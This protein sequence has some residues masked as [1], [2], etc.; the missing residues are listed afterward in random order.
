MA[1][2]NILKKYPKIGYCGIN[3]VLC[4]RYYTDGESRCSGCCGD[5]INISFNYCPFV[6]FAGKKKQLE[7]CSECDEFP[8]SKF[9][10]FKDIDSFVTHKNIIII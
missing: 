7:F 8:C 1:K 4:P 10:K 9:G 6:N 5:M 2:T 3:C